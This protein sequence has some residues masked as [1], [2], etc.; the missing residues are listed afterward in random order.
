M[1]KLVTVLIVTLGLML[2]LTATVEGQIVEKKTGD[3]ITIEV[4][5]AEGKTVNLYRKTGVATSATKL[6]A[7][8]RLEGIVECKEFK[9]T[10]PSGS[11]TVYRFYAIPVAS[12]GEFLD[13][14]NDQ[15]VK[16][17]K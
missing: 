14:T 3:V 1:I 16:R 7:V 10:M 4:C 5:G 11:T 13:A 9:T 6:D 17:V 8:S 15:R 12:N 2:V